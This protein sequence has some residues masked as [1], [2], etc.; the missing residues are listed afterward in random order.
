MIAAR[1][2]AALL[3][4]LSLAGCGSTGYYDW[5][6]YEDS[7]Y[8]VTVRPDGFDLA[9]EIDSLEQQLDKT[10]AKQRPIPP[11]LHAHLAYLHTVAGNADAARAHLEQEKALFPESTRFVD[12]LLAR[13]TPKS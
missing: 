5:G 10:E 6:R 7:V 11:G 2:L 8:N 12:F 3:L 4:V 13:L 9:A 1:P